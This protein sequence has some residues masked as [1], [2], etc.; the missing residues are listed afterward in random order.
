MRILHNLNNIQVL[1]I[2]GAHVKGQSQGAT[3]PERLD[4]AN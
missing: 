2:G 3:M 4:L 1:V